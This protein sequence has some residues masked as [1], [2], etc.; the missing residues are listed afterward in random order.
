MTAVPKRI[1]VTSAGGGAS[2]NLM[3]G[4]RQSDIPVFLI[5]TSSDKYSL[6]RSQADRNYLI[7]PARDEAGYVDALNH[8][9]ACEAID[10]IIPNSDVEVAVVS[11]LESAISARTYLPAHETILL[12]QD[13]LLLTKHLANRGID[14]PET[15]A[16]DSP[17]QAE[18]VFSCFE[19]PDLPW[20]RMRRG[21]GSKGSL[22][23]NRPERAASWLRYWEEVRGVPENMFVLCEYL[24][25]RDFAI[26]S[27][28]DKGDLVQAK[29]CERSS[30]L[31]G[32]VMPSGSS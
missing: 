29:S 15:Y 9:V 7:P 27:I 30:Y 13:K 20:C 4:L 5:G 23:V 26:Q 28:W 11:A 12:C 3:A 6:T 18:D 32:S 8:I 31:F 24:P 16:I 21:G 17:E 25:G 14:V 19:D 1:L 22:P 10:L 2:N